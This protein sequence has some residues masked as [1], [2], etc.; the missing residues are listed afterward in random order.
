MKVGILHLSDIHIENIDDWICNKGEKIAQAVWGTFEELDAIFVVVSGDVANKGFTEHYDHAYKFFISIRNYLQEQFSA[1]IFFIV[2]PGNHDCDFVNGKFDAKARLSFISTVRNSPESVDRGDSIFEGC[3]S[4]QEPF[5]YFINKLEPDLGYPVNPDIFY[6]IELQLESHTFYFNVFNTAW[7]SQK[8][9]DQG[10]LVFPTRLINCNSEKLS[11]AT[12]SISLFHHPDNWLESGNAREFRNITER[13]SDV[14]L[15]GHEHDRE[16][17]Q[18]QNPETGVS[19]QVI[20]APALQERGHEESSSFNLVIVD[21]D[22]KQQKLFEFKWRRSEYTVGKENDWQGFIR[23]RFLQKESFH[24]LPDF[25]NYLNSLGSLNANSRNH[26]IQLEDLFTTPRL[27][28]SSLKD[29]IMGKKQSR[30]VE[31]DNFFD[32]IYENKTAIIFGDTWQGKTTVAKK[33]FK[34]FRER[35]LITLLVD[36]SKFT[37]TTHESFKKVLREDFVYQYDGDLWAKFLQQPRNKRAL[38]ID[39]FGHSHKLNQQSLHKLLE[40]ANKFFEFVIVFAHTDLRLQQVSSTDSATPSLSD[41]VYWTMQPLDPSQRTR[42]IRRWVKLEADSS[43]EEAELINH[44]KQ[45]RTIIREAINNGLIASTPFYI[46]GAL[47]LIESLKTNPTAQFGSIGYIYQGVITNR[48]SGL[49]KT[50]TEIDRTF[51]VVSLIAHWL[52]TNNTDEIEAHEI[53]GVITKYNQKF[54]SRVNPSKFLAELQTAQILNRQVN[55]NWKFIGTHL[56]D[57]FVAKYL[58]RA[59]GNDGSPEREAAKATIQTMVQTI[60][61]DPHTRILLFLVYEA[62]SNT[63]LINY[64]LVQARSVFGT[65]EVSD[66]D[67]DVEFL[68][69]VEQ[70]ILSDNLL[71]SGDARRNLDKQDEA[72]KTSEEQSDTSM[73]DQFRKNLVKYTDDLDYFT[74]TAFALKTIELVGQ[75]VKSFS[76][77]IEGDLKQDLIQE[78]IDVGL[79]LLHAIFETNERHLK[80]LGAILKTLIRLYNARLQS[81]G[82][83]NRLDELLVLLH[84]D[85][86]YGVIK[87]TAQSIGHIDLQDSFTDVFEGRDQVS[88]RMVETAIRLDNYAPAARKLVEFAKELLDS[89]NKFAYNVLRRLVADYVNYSEIDTRQRQMLVEKFKL[90]GGTQYLL[91]TAKSDRMIQ[92][93][94]RKTGRYSP[95]I[96]KKK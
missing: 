83:I 12:F 1:K 41:Y 4:V 2:A 33:V 37:S 42:L 29:A 52:Y 61:Y 54:R 74:K 91:H 7:L 51:L 32:A 47:Q 72:E 35:E 43:M 66:L 69:D 94:P 18:K 22:T 89:K 78:C 16:V 73:T 79:R 38:I 60:V 64:I 67:S 82:L 57:F 76:G 34:D 85:F 17:Y 59:L 44:E 92:N 26:A 80:Q 55:G 28:E 20:K 46:F 96:K 8:D 50:S 93:R 21:L 6:Q 77:T 13:N 27:V 10:G 70:A 49:G 71:Q 88:Y 95:P 68:N 84:H 36:G 75:L 14:I 62:K 56:R 87:K 45:L 5:F 24:L 31:P 19:N 25:E 23:N 30:R 86:A 15:T 90:A 3:L 53:E 65:S 9:E 40:V 58:A 63:R 48:L 11:T 81:Q 39:N